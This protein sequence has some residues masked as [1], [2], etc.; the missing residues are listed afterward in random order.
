MYNF[1]FHSPAII[2]IIKNSHESPLQVREWAGKKTGLAY[3]QIIVELFN[4]C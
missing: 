2:K 1:Y 3:N 4:Y